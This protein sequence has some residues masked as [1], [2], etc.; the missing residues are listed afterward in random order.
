[1]SSAIP[2][3]LTPLLLPPVKYVLSPKNSCFEIFY[4]N[5]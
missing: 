2:K 3:L 4:L 5:V 1:M